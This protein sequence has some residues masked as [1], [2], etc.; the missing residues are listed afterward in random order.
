MSG[1]LISPKLES[2]LNASPLTGIKKKCT[3]CGKEKEATVKCFHKNRM[4]KDGL[5]PSCKECRSLQAKKYY[6]R[7]ITAITRRNK[8]YEIKHL[9]ES[10][11]R[12]KKYRDNNPG[13]VKEWQG[14]ARR[15]ANSTLKG[16]INYRMRNRINKCLR[17]GR[18][19]DVHWENIV[20]F[21]VEELKIHIEKQFK[22]GMTWE[23][24]MR[25]EIHI[26]H[27]IPLAVHNFESS[28]DIDFKRAWMMDNLQPM[29]AK[30]NIVKNSKITEPFQPSLLI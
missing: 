4:G 13:K 19:V 29:W 30:D 6:K 15:K 27:K 1:I 25:G 11:E 18:K 10:R 22:D 3:K 20:G 16:K 23:R 8:K 21:G 26:D 12:H 17:N 7:E 5:S 14:R 9:K 24:F 2:A 28:H